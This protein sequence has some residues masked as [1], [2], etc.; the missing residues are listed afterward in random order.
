MAAC[1]REER[2][3]H[4]NRI[5]KS[6]PNRLIQITSSFVRIS[7]VPA[8]FPVVICPYLCTMHMYMYVCV[9]IYI[10]IYIYTHI[11]T[12]LHICIYIYIYS[13]RLGRPNQSRALHTVCPT[14]VDVQHTWMSLLT[15]SRFTCLYYYRIMC[16]CVAPCGVRA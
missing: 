7:Y 16:M 11:H 8:L 2:G 13:N 4:P 6:H 5:T 15:I 9:H 1:R 10:Y 14:T 12:H 3:A